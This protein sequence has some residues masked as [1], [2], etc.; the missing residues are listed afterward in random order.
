MSA[1]HINTSARLSQ[2]M[3]RIVEPYSADTLGE[4]V[5][6]RSKQ[7]ADVLVSAFSINEFSGAA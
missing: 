3:T 5:T 2:P 1:L 7:Q 6:A 4:Q